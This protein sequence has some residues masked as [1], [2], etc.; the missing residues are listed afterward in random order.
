MYSGNITKSVADYLNQELSAWN[1]R[2]NWSFKAG[3]SI[4]QVNREIRDNMGGRL[5]IYA[6]RDAN[7]NC[8][9]MSNE[10]Q[11]IQ[12]QEAT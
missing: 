1:K 7:G 4:K 12:P 5:P 6:I 10:W 3:M 9:V 11:A 2:V 8:A